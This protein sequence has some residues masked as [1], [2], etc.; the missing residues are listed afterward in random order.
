MSPAIDQP[1]RRLPLREQACPGSPSGRGLFPS[2][3][4]SHAASSRRPTT[5]GA[6][7]SPFSLAKCLRAVHRRS[8]P[9]DTIYISNSGLV[10]A[11]NIAILSH[12]SLSCLSTMFKYHAP[13]HAGSGLT[14]TRKPQGCPWVSTRPA[15]HGGDF[16]SRKDPVPGD[17]KHPT[18]RRCFACGFSPSVR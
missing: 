4:C 9:Q 18:Y 6:P 3:S 16:E 2:C 13:L 5:V 7:Q 14:S 8:V 10:Q 1:A 12:D 15:F 11:G 17:R